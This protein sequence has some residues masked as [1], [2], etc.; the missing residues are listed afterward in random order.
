MLFR[1]L[2]FL[3]LWALPFSA[4]VLRSRRLFIRP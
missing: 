4:A 3:A 1:F 2:A